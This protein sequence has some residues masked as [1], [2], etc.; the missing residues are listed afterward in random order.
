ML[1]DVP[2]YHKIV[3]LD[4]EKAEMWLQVTQTLLEQTCG[5]AE[6]LETNSACGI[7]YINPGNYLTFGLTGLQHTG[8][9]R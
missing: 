3:R 6:S 8:N 4:K 7:D 2:G 1:H 5:T 9:H